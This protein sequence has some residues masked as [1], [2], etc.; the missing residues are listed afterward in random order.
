MKIFKIIFACFLMIISFESM[1]QDR[2]VTGTVRNERGEPIQGVTITADK[3]NN[4]QL[5]VIGSTNEKGEFSV[6]LPATFDALGLRH[7][8][9]VRTD[10]KLKPTDKHVNITLK[11]RANTIEE[12]VS[13]G[14]IERKVESLTGAATVI[15]IDDIKDAPSMNVTDLLQG[16]VAGLNVQ[17]NTGT[18]GMAGSVNIRGV[19]TASFA[20][21]GQDVYMK[22]TSPLYV[23]DGVP[24]EDVDNFEY[25]FQTQGP[26]IT[27][28]AMIPVDDIEEVVVLK[29]AQATSL[30][31]AQGAYGVILITTKRG[32]SRV[33]IVSYNTRVAVNTVPSLRSVLG[34]QYERYLRVNQILNNDRTPLDG[35]IYVNN[36]PMLADSINPYYNNS[37]NW[38][39]YFYKNAM[40]T[41]QSVSISGGEQ[42]FNYRMSPSYSKNRGIIANTG[43]ER[44]SLSANMT[45]RPTNKFM[46]SAVISSS[47]AKNSLGSGN[48]YQQTGVASGA[49]STSLL[50]SPSIYAGSYD[51]LLATQIQSDNK[52]GAFSSNISLE[53]EILRGLRFRSSGQYSFNNAHQDQFTPELLNSGRTKL[54]AFRRDGNSIY[55][56]N[57][58]SYS[59]NLGAK[60]NIT[61][62]VFHEARMSTSSSE[63]MT[64]QDVGNDYIQSG[65]GYN[66]R[67]ISGGTLDNLAE[68]RSLSYA[69]SLIYQFDQRFV[70][71]GSYRM[72]ASSG[73]GANVPWS[74]NPSTGFRWNISKEKFFEPL[75]SVIN[76]MSWRISYG[77]NI[78]PSSSRYDAYGTYSLVSGGYNNQPGITINL[79]SMPSTNLVPVS[80]TTLN[81]GL[82]FNLWKGLVN[83]GYDAYYKQ[84][85][86]EI[87]TIP[88]SSAHGFKGI[89][90][91]AQA[92]INIGHEFSL[93]Y[94]PKF[95]N[96][97]WKNASISFNMSLNNDYLAQLPEGKR[98]EL[99]SSSQYAYILRRLGTNAFSNVLFHYRGVYESDAAV[100]VD[101][102]TGY[103]Y[104]VGTNTGEDYFFRAGDPIFTDLNGDYILDENDLV[105]AGSSMPKVVG[106]AAFSLGY[107]D[108]SFQ[109]NFSFV[110]KRDI[111]N[112]ALADRFRNFYNP[113]DNGA[114]VPIDQYNY[115]GSGQGDPIYP[116]PFDFRRAT[117]VDPFRYN[118][119]LFQEDG[120][121][122]KINTATLSYN[123][124]ES[125]TKPKL[126]IS[127]ARLSFTLNNVYT[128]SNYSGPDPELVTAFGYD[129]SSGYPRAR[130][131]SVGLDIRF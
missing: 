6:K 81:S 95:R 44:Y 4:P 25:G 20:G 62:M 113:T 100:P 10:Y 130:D 45:Y 116:N 72:D 48:A 123:F 50:P 51:A 49:N 8:Q 70:L 115:Y 15:K 121:Y 88:L 23:V 40:T 80:T 82:D 47:L 122:F 129:S 64:V 29:D 109:T 1:A 38:Q 91:N 86:N 79:S 71:E 16:R 2:I 83:F 53:Y 78:K 13:V 9:Y 107:K 124:K 27:P 18:P 57:S 106:G 11:L 63:G 74:I 76:N 68:T 97:D 21:E 34:G 26:G 87:A 52:T 111:L 67:L 22:S 69:G 56:R 117:I 3:D 12:V 128:F 84:I 73:N 60:H 14:Y 24:I 90:L 37:T 94:R 105:I 103:R 102:S 39:S 99:S 89:K 85:D 104:R 54:Y 46:L 98:Q 110:V 19:N 93:S 28:L 127:S 43:F 112:N 59:T 58:L 120:S 119:T 33:P 35:I 36:T 32:N 17:L 41:T 55:T 126:G 65:I 118:S 42:S 31:G 114:L 61:A 7:L 75:T 108:F 131:F 101:P 96:K 30:Y 77:R 125:F 66:T 92:L 5:I